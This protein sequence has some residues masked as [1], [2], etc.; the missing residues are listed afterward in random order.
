MEAPALLLERN[1][2]MSERKLIIRDRFR[3]RLDEISAADTPSYVANLKRA[4]AE[5]GYSLWWTKERTKSAGGPAALDRPL[6]LARGIAGTQRLGTLPDRCAPALSLRPRATHRPTPREFERHSWLVV[7]SGVGDRDRTA[8]DLAYAVHRRRRLY[9]RH[10]GETDDLRTS[11]L[12]SGLGTSALLTELIGNLVLLVFALLILVLFSQRRSSVPRLFV[13]LMLL[14]SAVVI[15]AT[16][17][18]AKIPG[19][20]QVYAAGSICLRRRAVQQCAVDRLLSGIAPR[21]RD[22]CAALG[23][24]GAADCR[25]HGAGACQPRVGKSGAGTP[26]ACVGPD[27]LTGGWGWLCGRELTLDLKG[28]PHASFR[29]GPCGVPAFS[30]VAPLGL[31]FDVNA[32]PGRCPG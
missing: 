31:A 6:E 12:P 9:D 25:R 4:R 20:R 16:V 10:L 11:R 14:R 23:A 1:I 22:L 13:V 28:R 8:G 7:V 24:G 21:T 32:V 17:L 27:W 19:S 15:A 5:L 3:T 29:D 18:S 2:D 30:W 26:R